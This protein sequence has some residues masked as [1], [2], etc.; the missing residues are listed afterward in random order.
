MFCHVHLRE[1]DTIA[2]PSRIV[3]HDRVECVRI[4]QAMQLGRGDE[5]LR[6]WLENAK[7]DPLAEVRHAAI[8]E[9]DSDEV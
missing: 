9:P 6:Q 1:P 2:T 7:N 4:L 3:V 8:G 5:F